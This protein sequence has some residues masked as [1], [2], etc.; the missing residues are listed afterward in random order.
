MNTILEDASQDVSLQPYVP[1]YDLYGSVH[2]GLRFSLCELLSRFGQA[3]ATDSAGTQRLLDDLDGVLYML[4]AHAAHEN[5]HLHRAL[6]ARHAGAS[7]HLAGTHE[8]LDRKAAAVRVS[9]AAYAHVET[10][11]RAPAL[12]A[13][14]LAY[15]TLVGEHLVHMA[16]EEL[17][18]QRALD[19][20]Y[21]KEE[22][23]QIHGALLRDTGP[24]ESTVF[25]SAMAAGSSPAERA[26]LLLGFRAQAPEPAFVDLLGKVLPRLPPEQRSAL[27]VELRPGS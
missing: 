10:E 26:R 14:Y 19:R 24:E 20:L 9:A 22:L 6:E 8:R 12:R 16:D 13:L 7:A 25:M 18:A 23:G 4:D 17:H 1:K 3:D 11:A 27:L 2:K 21:E 15:S 5:A